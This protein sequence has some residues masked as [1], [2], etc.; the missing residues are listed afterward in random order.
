MTQDNGDDTNPLGNIRPILSFTVK[1]KIVQMR[2]SLLLR[3]ESVFLL[4]KS[5]S[6]Y[7]FVCVSDIVRDGRSSPSLSYVDNT[8]FLVVRQQLS[9]NKALIQKKVLN[10]NILNAI[11]IPPRLH[12]VLHHNDFLEGIGDSDQ[13]GNLLFLL[14]RIIDG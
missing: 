8:L 9:V 12:I 3:M 6:I 10:T 4:K 1:C 7:S 2:L 5:L 13:R 11:V 14:F